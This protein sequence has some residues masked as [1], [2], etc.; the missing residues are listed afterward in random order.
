M[1]IIDYDKCCWKDGKCVSSCCAETAQKCEGCVEVCP[2]DALK[3][4]DSVIF[5]AD[6]CIDC[7]ACIE[8]CKHDAIRQQG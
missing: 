7:G 4:E 5:D 2:V 6:K 1:I 3:R 8:A